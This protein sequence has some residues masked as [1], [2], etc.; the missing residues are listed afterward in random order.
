[1][2]TAQDPRH[3]KRIEAIQ[4]L[5]ADSF[6]KQQKVS[7]LVK[8]I[9]ANKK[10]I[11]D[12]IKSAAPTWPIRKLNKID[13]AILRLSVYELEK[14]SAP[15][16]VII[17]EAVE[18]AKTFGSENSPSFINGVL[19]TIYTG[20]QP[21]PRRDTMKKNNKT[22]SDIL[23]LQEQVKKLLSEYLGIDPKDLEED[24]SFSE[25]LHMNPANLSDFIENLKK[26]G[27]DTSSVNLLE[28]KTLTDL[29][30]SLN[31][32]EFIK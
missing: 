11:D 8:A 1:M 5:F 3:L 16:K 27:I 7:G 31:S 18:L 21:K 2:K 12:K 25:D 30:E 13:L 4:E 23:N 32:E 24:D 17:D 9:L 29:I 28:I 6:A 14:K 19:G 26:E 15:P 10:T 22:Q 20:E